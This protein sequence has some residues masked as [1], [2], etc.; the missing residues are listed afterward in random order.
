M[1][2]DCLVAE[3]A[4]RE[5]IKAG[6]ELLTQNGFD[7]GSL[8]LVTKASDKELEDLPRLREGAQG[9]EPGMGAL[10]GAILGG[11]FTAPIAAG[12]MVG[13]FILV[14]PLVGVGVGAAVGSVLTG[15][16]EWG[17]DDTARNRFEASVDKGNTLLIVIGEKSALDE[18]ENLLATVGVVALER[19]SNLASTKA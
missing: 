6:W 15:A 18:A 9:S 14:G 19:F 12:T 7:E 1:K 5:D 13:P 16:S 11:V 3:F 8:S 17:L 10:I 4:R 2:E